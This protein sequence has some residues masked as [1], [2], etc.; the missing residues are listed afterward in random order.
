MQLYTCACPTA[1]RH[2]VGL[3]WVTIGFLGWGGWDW[4]MSSE[5]Y[6]KGLRRLHTSSMFLCL[7]PWG[8]MS[9]WMSLSRHESR[10]LE[11]VCVEQRVGGAGSCTGR[12]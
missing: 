8:S 4:E 11:L 2:P 6:F 5:I 3:V 7:G 1:H 10:F 9:V 12:T